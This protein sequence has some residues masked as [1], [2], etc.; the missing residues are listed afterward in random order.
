[1]VKVALVVLVAVP[2]RTPVLLF[3]V[4]HA[5]SP[6]AVHAIGVALLPDCVIVCVNNTPI[7]GVGRDAGETVIVGQIFTL[8]DVFGLAQLL[9]S[10]AFT[11]TAAPVVPLVTAV[12]VPPI[13]PALDKDKPAGHEPPTVDHV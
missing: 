10:V 3:K 12:G 8:I 13:T 2:L 1:M 7:V 6:V 11:I 5:G 4:S 9:A